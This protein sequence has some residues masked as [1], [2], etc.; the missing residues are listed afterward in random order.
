MRGLS[1]GTTRVGIGYGSIPYGTVP[2]LDASLVVRNV[3]PDQT[4]S[5]L[6]AAR[7]TLANFGTVSDA[8]WT[9][10]GLIY[11]R[12]RPNS[13]HPAID[14]ATR[15]RDQLLRASTS[16]VGPR[17]QIIMTRYR[18][19]MPDLREDVYVYPVGPVPAPPAPRPESREELVEGTSVALPSA[20][21]SPAVM[22]AAAFV[23]VSLAAAAIYI[24]RS[25]VDRRSR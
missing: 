16:F 18:V 22:G 23:A 21:G 5:A 8:R 9:P 17:S 7:S 20:L 15:I 24:S 14:H 19:N 12:W 6:S 4:D 25:K 13:E 1:V 11:V 2:W 3:T 10:D